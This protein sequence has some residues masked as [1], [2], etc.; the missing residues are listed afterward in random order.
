M[1]ER[2]GA[3]RGERGGSPSKEQKPRNKFSD[4]EQKRAGG[5]LVQREGWGEEGGERGEEGGG[6]GKREE[7]GGKGEGHRW[8]LGTWGRGGVPING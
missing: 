5:G 4:E 2:E 7:K 8:V 3:R 1:G 6:R